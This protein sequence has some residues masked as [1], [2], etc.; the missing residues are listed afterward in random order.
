MPLPATIFKP[1]FSIT[2]MSHAVFQVG[3]L[4]ASRDFYL[5][6]LGM[7]ISDESADTIW[8]RGLEEGCHHSLVLKRG[9]PGCQRVGFR[10]LMEEDLDLV[11]AHFSAAGLPTQW[12]EVPYQSRTLHTVDPVGTPLEFCVSMEVRPRLFH[13]V[14]RYRGASVQRADH[15][16]VLTPGVA[17]ALQ[18]YMGMGFR[19]SEY[20]QPDD[21]PD[22]VFVFLQ[23]KGNPHDVVFANRGTLQLHHIAY[24]VPDSAALIHTAELMVRRGEGDRVEFGPARH[25]SPGLARFLYI[26]DPDGHRIELFPSHY[27]TMD[28]E[29]APVRWS[30]EE[31]RIGGWQEPPQRWLDEAMS[32]V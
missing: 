13:H 23:R 2:R 19:L 6:V 9:A 26:R 20:V 3:D 28:V 25:F 24:T 11:A 27:Q 31:F 21:A 7:A 18:F 29:D 12:V 30:P 5:E 10:V 4:A 1:P 17:L 32:F 15:V 22:P 14:E 16:Q 8:L